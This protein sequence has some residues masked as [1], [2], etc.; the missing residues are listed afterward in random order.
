MLVLLLLI[1]F[2]TNHALKIEVNI[3]EAKWSI[4]IPF[5]NIWA[6]TIGCCAEREI[7]NIVPTKSASFRR[8][9]TTEPQFS[10]IQTKTKR[11]HI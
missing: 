4:P 7:K 6:E 1:Y 9:A 3:V 2:R 10:L 8:K 5:N 11:Y